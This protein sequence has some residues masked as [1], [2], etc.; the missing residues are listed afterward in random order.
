MSSHEGVLSVMRDALVNNEAL[1]AHAL[2]LG[3]QH[4]LRALPYEPGRA[5]RQQRLGHRD[6][7]EAGGEKETQGQGEGE[8]EGGKDGATLGNPY[9]TRVLQVSR[10][11]IS[12]LVCQ[13]GVYGGAGLGCEKGGGSCVPARPLLNRLRPIRAL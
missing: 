7:G 10:S 4:R 9:A 3:L 13:R 1:A 2:R 11:T 12:P 5:L 6:D 8:E